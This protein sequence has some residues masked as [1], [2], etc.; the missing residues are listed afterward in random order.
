MAFQPGLPGS[1]F[2]SDDALIRRIQ[3]LERDMRELRAANPFAPMGMKPVAGGVNITGDL[4]VTGTL[5]LPAGIINNDALANPITIAQASNSAIG[6][7]V[8]TTDV[9]QAVTTVDVPAG[10]SRAY[11]FAL[12]NVGA[13]G[14]TSGDYVY[15]STIIEGAASR[16]VKAWASSTIGSVAVTTGKSSVL[17]G[18]NGGTIS[19][20]VTIRADI[21]RT[22][23][24]ANR[25]YVE[26]QVIFLR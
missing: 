15:S 19:I 7:S 10:F 5:S 6:F 18:L 24:S 11:V 22:A 12:C 17:T 8:S 4:A 3:D 26:A 20:G 16:E 21:P 14:G 13:L 25:A 9:P 1:Q 2:P 23:N